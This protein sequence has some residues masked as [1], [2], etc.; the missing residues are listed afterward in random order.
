MQE[1]ASVATYFTKADD[2]SNPHTRLQ[3][4]QFSSLDRE[5]SRFYADTMSVLKAA[6]VPFLVTGAYAFAC[7]TGIERHTKDFD[8]FITA[9]NLDAALE[10]LHEAGYETDLTFPHWLA[11]VFEG[12]ASVDLIFASGNGLWHVNQTW[13]DRAVEINVLNVQA[14]LCPLEETILMK[15]FIMERERFDG[16]DVAHL[17]R[18]CAGLI[19]W[20][21]LVQL[22]GPHWRVLFGHLIL[23]G[24]IYPS[25]RRQIPLQIL[26]DFSR[27]MEKEQGEDVPQKIC[28][29]TLLSR[30]QYLTDVERA[31]YF[32][33]REWP[34]GGM[35]ES[36]I[37]DWT[38]A[39]EPEG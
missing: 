27:I 16:A 7:Y 26:R 38:A 5:T 29:G 20:Q 28:R 33:A 31:G 34:I 3:M 12:D 24:Y 9:K 36:E 37:N 22:Y 35:T 30:S 10:A 19:D 2:P 15:S 11:K 25:E 1:Y 18:D 6:D 17:L 39:I 14:L 13:F 23:F 8:L 4:P 32:D 21:Y